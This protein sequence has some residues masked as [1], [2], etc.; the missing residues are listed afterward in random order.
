LLGPATVNGGKNSLAGGDGGEGVACYNRPYCAG[1]GNAIL[2]WKLDG[3]RG[4]QGQLGDS[5][6]FELT[7]KNPKTETTSLKQ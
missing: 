6:S 1:V 3:Q 5:S 2:I 4:N 7:W